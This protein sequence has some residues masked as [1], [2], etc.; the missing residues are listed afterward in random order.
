MTGDGEGEVHLLF[1]SSRGGRS[2]AFMTNEKAPI[3]HATKSPVSAYGLYGAVKVG[4]RISK[5]IDLQLSKY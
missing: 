1:F 3:D 4:L 5:N 2:T